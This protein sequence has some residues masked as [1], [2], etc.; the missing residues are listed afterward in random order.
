MREPFVHLAVVQTHT[1]IHC[2]TGTMASANYQMKSKTLGLQL[3]KSEE[4]LVLFPLFMSLRDRVPRGSVEASVL[5]CCTFGL[6]FT[7]H[8]VAEC[9]LCTLRCN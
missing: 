2:A 1:V 9:G 7:L 4:R 5:Q 6:Q 3:A 8:L